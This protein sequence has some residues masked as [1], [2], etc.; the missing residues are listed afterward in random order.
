MTWVGKDLQMKKKTAKTFTVFT[1][2]GHIKHA[3]T[4]S[5]TQVAHLEGTGLP[6]DSKVFVSFQFFV[7]TIKE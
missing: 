4:M 3:Y 5:E 6:S 1:K 2:G 7:V